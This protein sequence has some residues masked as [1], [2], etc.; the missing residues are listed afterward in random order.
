[1][2]AVFHSYKDGY[3]KNSLA[4]MLRIA[5]KRT[6]LIT[7]FVTVTDE[8]RKPGTQVLVPKLHTVQLLPYKV[9]S[10]AYIW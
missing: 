3:P 7:P 4:L 2:L 1:M 6:P 8:G 5:L 9:L 10:T